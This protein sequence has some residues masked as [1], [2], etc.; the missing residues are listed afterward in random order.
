MGGAAIGW[1]R[2]RARVG[3]RL[4]GLGYPPEVREVLNSAERCLACGRPL[5]YLPDKDARRNRGYCSMACYR[6]KPP[7]MVAAERM[8]GEPIREAILDR[9]NRGQTIEAVANQLGVRKQ[10]LYR[11]LDLLGIRRRCV[12]E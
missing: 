7:R 4:T 8:L 2:S 11:W 3:R 12:W 9:L 10:A 1:G 5:R 6:A